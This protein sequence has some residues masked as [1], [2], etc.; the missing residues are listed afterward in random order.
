[1]I[2]YLVITVLLVNAG[3]AS[4]AGGR[5][6]DRLPKHCDGTNLASTVKNTNDNG[7][8]CIDIVNRFGWDHASETHFKECMAMTKGVQDASTEWL[9]LQQQGC[10]FHD[11]Q[12]GPTEGQMR[13]IKWL[14]D[15]M[16]RLSVRS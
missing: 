7:M 2:K 15:E 4:A 5:G 10:G 14:A 13:Y 8:L 6:K 16:V 11:L 9:S 12:N 1:M 3:F